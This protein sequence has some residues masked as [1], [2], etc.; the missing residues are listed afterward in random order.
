MFGRVRVIEAR[1]SEHIRECSERSARFEA[2]LKTSD[3]SAA[4][5]RRKIYD[6]VEE[7]ATEARGR[8]REI[9][10]AVMRVQWWII[11]ALFSLVALA[12]AS[13]YWLSEKFHALRGVL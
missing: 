9:D 1:L 8:F 2:A 5:S 13:A 11:G 12:A 6:K 10:R 3:D 7:H 4:Q